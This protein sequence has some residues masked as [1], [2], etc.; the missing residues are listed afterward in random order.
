MGVVN[1]ADWPF[2]LGRRGFRA[3]LD[4]VGAFTADG[5]LQDHR[6]VRSSVTRSTSQSKRR[7]TQ[8]ALR[9]CRRLR[10]RASRGVGLLEDGRAFGPCQR[11]FVRRGARPDCDPFATPRWRARTSRKSWGRPTVLL[12]RIRSSLPMTG[13]VAPPKSIC[14]RLIHASSNSTPGS[15]S[16]K[17]I[18]V[19]LRPSQT[20]SPSFALRNACTMSAGTPNVESPR[21]ARSMFFGSAASHRST[22]FV[23]RGRPW[24]ATACP[25][26]N[27]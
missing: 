25:P 1:D 5:E 4:L 14:P 9:G 13:I 6:V 17:S 11:D 10:G 22:S 2:P 16:K 24:A 7:R 20:M 3:D 19:G 26:T 8:A 27:K 21:H 23:D 12:L 18:R 15:D